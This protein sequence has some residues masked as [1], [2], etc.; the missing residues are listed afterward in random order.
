M[1]FILFPLGWLLAHVTRLMEIGYVLRARGHEVIFAGEDPDKAPRSRMGLARDAGFRTVYAREPNFPYAWDRFE[2]HGWLASAWDIL[3]H[4]QWAPLDRILES[5]LEV[6]DREKPDMIV[7]DATISVSTAAYIAGIP[8]AG[9][10]NGY[11]D[12]FYRPTSI[13]KPLIHLLDAS[14]LAPQRLRVYRKRGVK[15]VNALRLLRSIPLISPDLPGL[16]DPPRSFANWHMVGPFL[17]QPPVGKP[18]WWDELDDGQTNIYVTMGSTGIIDT[19]L[20]RTFDALAK[21]PYRYLLTTAGQ[22]SEEVL[23]RAPSNFR[24]AKYAP[25]N[26]LLQ[27]CRGLIFHGGNGTMYQALAAGVPMIA[28]PSHLE[29]QLAFKVALKRGFGLQ[30]APRTVTGEQLVR[31]LRRILEEPSF[32]ENAQRYSEAVKNARGPE[33][34]A[35]IIERTARE[36]RPAGWQ[37]VSNRRVRA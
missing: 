35:D 21:T 17:A 8:A 9:L 23:A 29:Q 6:I 33:A 25:G 7:G 32:R 10:M 18:E 12:Q 37:L 26:E 20:L 22:A 1:K 24:I 3:T 5:Q 4:E 19:F 28:L 31:T 27:H 36:G 14:R 13:F 16:Y 15:P 30:L 34:A 2:K 11:N